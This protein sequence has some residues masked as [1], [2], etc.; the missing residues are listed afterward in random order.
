MRLHE[1]APPHD[2]RTLTKLLQRYLRHIDVVRDMPGAA[3]HPPRRPHAQQ[4]QWWE[5]P[6][7]LPLKE[8]PTAPPAHVGGIVNDGGFFRHG[9]ALSESRETGIFDTEGRFSQRRP[10]ASATRK[11]GM[12]AVEQAALDE[13]AGI[14]DEEVDLNST[15]EEE[16]DDDESEGRVE[17]DGAP[18][19]SPVGIE[20]EI[21]RAG[22]FE[23]DTSDGA[24]A[25]PT[26]D[27]GESAAVEVDVPAG[28]GLEMSEQ[29]ETH[30]PAGVTEDKAGGEEGE[31]THEGE[32][33]AAEL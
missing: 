18:P 33:D 21:E 23:A 13:A 2:Q 3:T 25:G 19:R 14:Q 11:S 15:S 7:L 6:A 32:D 10:D 22:G 12:S 1:P 17:S 28:D 29:E 20:A 9:P 4:Q 8:W 30:E 5:D 31:E 27:A 16:S 24:S 26:V